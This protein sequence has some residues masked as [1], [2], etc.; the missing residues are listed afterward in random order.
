MTFSKSQRENAAKNSA[1][2]AKRKA[3]Q[4][5]PV[6][7]WDRAITGFKKVLDDVYDTNNR[8]TP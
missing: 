5:T 2:A 1:A 6:I 8:G 3:E 4:G 7:N